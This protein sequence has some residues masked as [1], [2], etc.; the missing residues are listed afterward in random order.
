MELPSIKLNIFKKLEYFLVLKK[1]NQQFDAQFEIVCDPNTKHEV[2][3][4]W[5]I[6]KKIL[7]WTYAY[8]KYLDSSFEQYDFDVINEDNKLKDTFISTREIGGKILEQIMTNSGSKDV[9]RPK[10]YEKVF[11]NLL[12]R[13]FAKHKP[14]TDKYVI[15]KE[16]L[17]FGELLWFLYTPSRIISGNYYDKYG[18]THILE[19][20]KIAKRIFDLQLHALYGFYLLGTFFLTIQVLE[21]IGILD[22][23]KTYAMYWYWP[24][25][26]IKLLLGI[27]ISIPFILFF[28]S[29]I[30]NW[31]Y[32]NSEE[33]Q[34]KYQDIEKMKRNE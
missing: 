13:G 34:K 14:N 4:T 18:A 10:K 16:G 28:Y 6:E 27:T 33:Y 11:G 17:A 26:T 8:H 5:E 1:L 15:T 29:L 20:K 2:L 7:F 25:N 24:G 3:P 9:I 21:I 31:R 12:Q 23:V 22:D 19:L 30:L 32:E